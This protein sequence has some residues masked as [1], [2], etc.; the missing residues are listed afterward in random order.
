MFQLFRA[1]CYLMGFLIATSLLS[2]AHVAFPQAYAAPRN[3][4]NF[5][6]TLVFIGSI[7]RMIHMLLKFYFVDKFNRKDK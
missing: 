4:S 5:V 1:L 2:G 7:I 6:I 3:L